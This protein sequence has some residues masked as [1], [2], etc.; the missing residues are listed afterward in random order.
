MFVVQTLQC[1]T[2]VQTPK[3]MLL[4]AF[5]A[6]SVAQSTLLW[7]F[8]VSIPVCFAVAGQKMAKVKARH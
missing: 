4:Y 2:F 1:P 7:C 8:P 6:S 3:N 5:V